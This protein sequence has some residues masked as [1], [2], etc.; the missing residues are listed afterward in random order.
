MILLFGKA[1]VL[2]IF[3][4]LYTSASILIYVLTYCRCI[5]EIQNLNIVW[6]YTGLW[7]LHLM[8]KG[9]GLSETNCVACFFRQRQINWICDVYS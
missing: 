3:S 7:R 6:L 9:Q 8:W 4:S 1:T 5:E 2:Y